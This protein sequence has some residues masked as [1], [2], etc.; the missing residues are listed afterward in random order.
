MKVAKVSS[1]TSTRDYKAS[2]A[3]VNYNSL[4]NSRKGN[5]AGGSRSDDDRSRDTFKRVFKEKLQ[6]MNN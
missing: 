6:E 5:D 1:M 2:N 3:S 4:R